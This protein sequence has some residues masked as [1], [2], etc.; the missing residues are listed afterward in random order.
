MKF[1][2]CFCAL[3]IMAILLIL[4]VYPVKVQTSQVSAD[5][6]SESYP[7]AFMEEEEDVMYKEIQAETL[8]DKAIRLD[9]T[10]TKTHKVLLRTLESRGIK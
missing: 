7:E 6:I 3:L 4:N 1:T 8:C 10:Q 2:L 5:P 9:H